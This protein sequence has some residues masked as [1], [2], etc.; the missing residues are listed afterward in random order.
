[1]WRAVEGIFKIVEAHKGA[2]LLIDYGGV[3][4]S[5]IVGRV[6]NRDATEDELL[7]VPGV[8]DISAV[9]NFADILALINR[10]PQCIARLL[11]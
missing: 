8:A 11:H 4:R 7:H 9:V 1:M 6:N 3:G 2:C 5:Q 10:H